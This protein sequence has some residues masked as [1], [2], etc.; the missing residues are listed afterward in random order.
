VLYLIIL[1][2]SGIGESFR[3]IF[4]KVLDTKNFQKGR[5]PSRLEVTL[6]FHQFGQPPQSL[7]QTSK[8][9]AKFPS[10]IRLTIPQ[11]RKVLMSGVVL[12][13]VLGLTSGP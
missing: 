8:H 11:T 12:V 13:M 6:R 7:G 5:D 10:L 2:F 4:W 3:V 1:L 9:S